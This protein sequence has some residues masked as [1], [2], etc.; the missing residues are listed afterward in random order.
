MLTVLAQSYNRRSKIEFSLVGSFTNCWKPC[1]SVNLAKIWFGFSPSTS[2][3]IQL[4]SLRL[5]SLAITFGT[6]FEKNDERHFTNDTITVKLLIVRRRWKVATN[7]TSLSML[8]N[9]EALN[10]IVSFV[11]IHCRGFQLKYIVIIN[12]GWAT[13]FML[14][15]FTSENWVIL[16]LDDTVVVPWAVEPCFSQT[17]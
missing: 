6:V 2:I 10:Y 9:K 8:R 5:K 12:N 15:T 17:Q 14:T 13:M 1:S 4:M 7:N 16:I 3:L 11:I